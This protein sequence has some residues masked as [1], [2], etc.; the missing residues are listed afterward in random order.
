MQRHEK[1]NLHDRVQLPVPSSPC[2]VGKSQQ[3]TLTCLRHHTA[4]KNRLAPNLK[5]QSSVKHGYPYQEY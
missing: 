5:A 1:M 3:P 4:M 2:P